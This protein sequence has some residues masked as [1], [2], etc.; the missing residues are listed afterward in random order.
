MK[1][2]LNQLF[3]YP[4]IVI[5][6]YFPSLLK[7]EI[8]VGIW[9]SILSHHKIIKA[10]NDKNGNSIILTDGG[11]VIYDLNFIMNNIVK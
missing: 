8:Q 10:Q 11:I 6:F 4:L 9:E 7:S 5:F 3:I 1:N 2:L